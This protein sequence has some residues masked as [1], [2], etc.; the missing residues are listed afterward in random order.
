MKTKRLL[1]PTLMAVAASLSFMAFSSTAQAGAIISNGTITM[2]INDQGHLNVYG[3]SPSSGTGTTAVG[4]RYNA[5]GSEATAPGCLC[6]GWGAGIVSLGTSGFANVSVDGVQNLSLISFSSTASTATSVVSIGGA[7]EITHF[8]HPTTKTDNLYQVDVSIKNLTGKDLSA[9]D[10]R[11]RRVMDWDIEPTAF[12]EYV[13]V[14]G[15]PAALGIANGSNLRRVGDDGFASA[16][17]LNDSSLTISC[18]ANTNFTDCGIDD[19]GALFDFEFAALAAGATTSFTTY[20]G[21]AGNEADADAARLA[22]GAGL[23]SYGQSARDAAT[24]TPNTFIFGFGAANGVF[25]PVPPGEVPEPLSLAL[26]G[27]GFAGLGFARR[28]KAI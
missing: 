18:P 10:L 8:Y 26:F 13:T 9:A 12:S 19:H 5:T 17:P 22:V 11:Y 14:G 2:G 21:A 27:I 23:Y 6:E 16:N 24:G 3:G 4:L 15:V 7:L 1:R 28:R 25:I 20:Y